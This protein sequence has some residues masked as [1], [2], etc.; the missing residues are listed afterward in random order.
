MIDETKLSGLQISVQGLVGSLLAISSRL[1]EMHAQRLLD[2]DVQ[3]TRDRMLE[4][5]LRE[6]REI[7]ERNAE[8]H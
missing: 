5:S 4:A 3:E 6:I 2:L 8:H 1:D 7:I